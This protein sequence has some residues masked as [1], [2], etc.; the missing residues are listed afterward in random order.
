MITSCKVL[1]LAAI[2]LF[3]AFARNHFLPAEQHWANQRDLHICINA[4]VYFN[5][6]LV[7]LSEARR[8]R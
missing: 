7:V 1:S 2:E 4:D 6:D 5:F 8:A 3:T